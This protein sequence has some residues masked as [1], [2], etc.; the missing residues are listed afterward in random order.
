MNETF[1]FCFYFF[2]KKQECDFPDDM[3]LPGIRPESQQQ[4]INVMEFLN[5]KRVDAIKNDR[6]SNQ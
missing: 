2:Y 3:R 4:E 6:N 5:I 1:V